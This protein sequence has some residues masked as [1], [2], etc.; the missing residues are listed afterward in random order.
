MDLTGFWFAITL[1]GTPEYWGYFGLFSLAGYFLLRVL[2]RGNP[3]WKKAK[4][5]I[6]RF[7]VI[8]LPSIA[9]FF[10]LMLGL[11][12][13]IFIPR[14]CTPC[15]DGAASCNPFCDTD[16]SFPS[17]HS[18]TIFVVFT[19]LYLTIR[20]R[21]SLALFIIPILVSFSRIALDVHTP[22]DV[23]A[24]A[25]LGL[26]IPVLASKFLPKWHKLK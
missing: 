17:G 12:T 3:G 15:L 2:L 22:L 9:L 1:L 8:F 18:G 19:S 4:P 23:L 13:F 25:L 11:K 16:S 24:G 14:P 21:S 10:A 7:L 5:F 6:K 26:I 20:K